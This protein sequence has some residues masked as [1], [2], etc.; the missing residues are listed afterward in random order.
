MSDERRILA[1]ITAELGATPTALATTKAQRKLDALNADAAGLLERRVGVLA[2]FT[3]DMLVPPLR[4][5]AYT[6]GFRFDVYNAPYGQYLQEL[7]NPAS[8][9][10]SHQPEIVL[11]AVRL[12][13]AC[14]ELYYGFNSLTAERIDAICGQ[15]Q[16]DL[17]GALRGFRSRSH[18]RILLT[19]YEQP[20]YASLGLAEATAELSQ[21]AVIG[22]MNAWLRSLADEIG[23][24]YIVDIDQVAARCGHARWD[25]AKMRLLARAPI[26]PD[27]AWD[28]AGA[29]TRVVRAISG[30]AK[31]VLALDCDNTLWGGVLGDVGIEG[32]HLGHD[33][34]GNAFRALQMRA[35]ELFHRGV[36]LVVASKNELS[37]VKQVFETHPEM[38]L[39]P[40]HIAFFGVNWE[41][42]PGN[43]RRAAEVLNLG[44]DSFV[45][46]DDHEVECA[47]M[48]EM[49]PEVLTVQMPGDPADYEHTLAR[50]DCFDNLTISAEDRQRGA[51]YKQEAERAEL[52]QGATDLD[53]FYHGLEM[54]A[55]MARNDAAGLARAAQLT[56]RTNQFNMTTIRRT[57]SDVLALMNAADS[58]VVTMRLVDRFGDN[59]IVGMAIVTR[60]GDDAVLD[61]FLMSCRVLG[62]TVEQTLVAWLGREAMARG[63]KRLVGRYIPTKKN[64]PF[65]KFYESVGM[66]LESDS[67]ETQLW[68]CPLDEASPT[69]RLPGYIDIEV[70]E[71]A[72]RTS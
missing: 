30:R 15:F 6:D 18:A 5:R 16:A 63:A 72:T 36:V 65:G 40:E 25:N 59:G 57:E 39:R 19:N 8:G 20:V 3:F 12:Q 7:V 43:L 1:D 51:M 45:F 71:G 23:A 46:L 52:R 11:V 26:A 41:P 64:T 48:R 31:K 29:V 69:L 13:D 37:N 42:K 4:T 9:L 70:Q 62:R 56:Q 60:E 33:Y 27:C 14:P 49:A 24:A 21:G 67:G 55:I 28:Y 22:R 50:L 35:L 34:P 38:V 10:A 58:D 44:L 32:I 17:G 54:R 66:T 53:T 2:S 47:M 68:V 61:T